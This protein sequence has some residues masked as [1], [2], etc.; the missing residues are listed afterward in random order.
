MCNAYAFHKAH[1]RPHNVAPTL[2]RRYFDADRHLCTYGDQDINNFIF[3][4]NKIKL[5]NKNFNALPGLDLCTS[6]SK[7]VEISYTQRQVWHFT[8]IDLLQQYIFIP[9]Y[10]FNFSNVFY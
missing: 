1:V 5:R 8:A 2:K 9:V 3:P 10:K 4:I 6:R 7:H